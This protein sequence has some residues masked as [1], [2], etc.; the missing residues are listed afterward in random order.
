MKALITAGG[1]GT[2]MRPLTFSSN[3]H[4]I[5]LANKPLIFYAIE[6][7]AETGIKEVGI[8]YNPGQKEELE[9]TLGD[10]HRWGLRFTYILQEKPLGLAHIVQCCQKFIGKDKFVM[11]LGDNIFYGGIRPLVDYYQ[12]SK[13]PGL[14]TIIHHPENRRMGVPYFDKGGRLI[15]CVEKPKRPP[16]DWAIPGLYFAS[17]HIFECFRGKAAI[18]PSARGEY[19][20]PSAFQ[21]L[22]DH[23]YPIETREFKGIWRDPGKFDDWLDTNQFLL[24]KL[25]TNETKSKLQEGVNLEGRVKIG[26]DCLISNSFLRG[27]VI[28]GDNVTIENSFIGPYSSIGDG[29][30]IKK[31]KIEN[32]ILVS[33]VQINSPSRPIDSSLIGEGTIIEGDPGPAGDVKLFIG[34][35]CVLKI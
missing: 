19:E 12:K 22:I 34:N 13:S 11:H 8:N 6:A 32:S 23:G 21:W 14:L 25:L 7:I 28:I 1:K 4:L 33:N 24:D 31:A 5:P 16:H 35:Q 3:K 20:I 29:C 2:R 9:Q 26:K 17:Y 27:P 30:Q 15:K 10:G 18:K